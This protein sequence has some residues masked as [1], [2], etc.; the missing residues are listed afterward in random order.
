MH[1][2]QLH[3]NEHA[4]VI[5]TTSGRMFLILLTLEIISDPFLGSS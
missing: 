1:K 5:P 4:Y 2:A 3:V